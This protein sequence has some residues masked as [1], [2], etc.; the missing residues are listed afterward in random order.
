MKQKSTVT[1]LGLFIALVATV[2]T[3]MGIFSTGG[4]GNYEHTSIR[5]KVVAIYGKGLYKHMSAEVAPQGIAQDYVTLFIGVPL[6][7]ISLF[8]ARSGS[9]KGRFWLAGTLAYFLVTY[10][11]YTVRSMYN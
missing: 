3:S 1:V 6:L 7:L 2:A 5:G 4:P 11:F 9:L 10:L 8:L